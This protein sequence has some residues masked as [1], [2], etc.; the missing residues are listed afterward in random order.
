[1]TDQNRET[2]MRYWQIMRERGD[3]PKIMA[4]SKSIGFSLS[5]VTIYKALWR[6]QC[7]P[8]T[9]EVLM[10]YYETKKIIPELINQKV[11]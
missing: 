10:K 7:S 5:D 6:E 4:F 11:A 1:M 2:I 8:A 9:F 3:M